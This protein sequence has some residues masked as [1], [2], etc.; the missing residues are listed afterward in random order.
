MPPDLLAD[1]VSLAGAPVVVETPGNVA[2]HRAD[3]DFVR[4]AANRAPAG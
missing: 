4:R 3:M 2:D 1:V